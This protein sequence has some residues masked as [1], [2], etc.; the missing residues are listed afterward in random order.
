M[1]EIAYQEH[2]KRVNRAKELHDTLRDLYGGEMDK[3][4]L[5]RR[6]RIDRSITEEEW[7][8]LKDYGPI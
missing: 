2:W 3:T 6:A 5:Y 7:R 4:L 8:L 1:N